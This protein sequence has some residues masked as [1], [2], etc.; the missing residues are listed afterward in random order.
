MAET[1]LKIK[2]QYSFVV[3]RIYKEIRLE[4]FFEDS[5][6]SDTTPRNFVETCLHLRRLL[7]PEDISQYVRLELLYNVCQTAWR[8][9]SLPCNPQ[10][11]QLFFV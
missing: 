4:L 11:S 6:F 8:H 2:L 7:D 1:K 10:I 3:K 5:V 9:I